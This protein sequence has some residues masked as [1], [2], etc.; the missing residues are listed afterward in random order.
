MCGF[1]HGA[2]LRSGDG[3][4]VS[5]KQVRWLTYDGKAG[6]QGVSQDSVKGAKGFPLRP[7]IT[8]TGE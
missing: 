6:Y 4:A 1:C 8:S 2:G 3:C 7:Y 5:C